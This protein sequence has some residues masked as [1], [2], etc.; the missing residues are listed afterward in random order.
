MIIPI[1]KKFLNSTMGTSDPKPLNQ[2]ITE[3]LTN[4]FV[5]LRNLIIKGKQTSPEEH[6]VQSGVFSNIAYQTEGFPVTLT[7]GITSNSSYMYNVTNVSASIVC[8]LRDG[9]L[10]EMTPAVSINSEESKMRLHITGD[11]RFMRD[12]EGF[13]W[14]LSYTVQTLPRKY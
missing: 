8:K 3:S 4:L 6:F 10:V 13:S 1:V 2:I 12:T 11:G 14:V 9:T 7:R 5:E